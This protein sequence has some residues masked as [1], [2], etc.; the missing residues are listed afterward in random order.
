MAGGAALAAHVV[1]DLAEHVHPPGRF[2]GSPFGRRLAGRHLRLLQ[3]FDEIPGGLHEPLFGQAG[4]DCL[5]DRRSSIKSTSAATRSQLTRKSLTN[6][7]WR[8]GRT[9]SS[10][11]CVLI[12]WISSGLAPL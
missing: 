1:G 8:V 11:I 5:L 4:Q 10:M 2:H 12:R 7:A 3:V 6:P 9:T